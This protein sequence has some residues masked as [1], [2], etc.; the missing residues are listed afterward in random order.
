MHYYLDYT[1][2][3]PHQDPNRKRIPGM[4]HLALIVVEDYIIEET[5]KA[6][7]VDI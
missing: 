5:L 1:D 3:K 4:S 7:G 2:I 6:H